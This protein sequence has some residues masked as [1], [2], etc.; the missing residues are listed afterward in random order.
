MG[1]SAALG[2]IRALAD[3]KLKVPEDV[4]VMGVDGVEVGRYTTPRLSTVVQPV[5]EI[6][7]QS[8]KVLADLMENGGPPKH[9][10]VK[11][12]VEIRACLFSRAGMAHPTQ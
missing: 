4:S 7:R 9:V 2:V 1:D 10:T 6:A 3:L 8:A 11:A 12:A 5:K